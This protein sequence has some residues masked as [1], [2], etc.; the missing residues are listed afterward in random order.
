MYVVLRHMLPIAM[1]ENSVFTALF[2]GEHVLAATCV[3][4][5]RGGVF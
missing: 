2:S 5:A 1:A 3:S 4:V